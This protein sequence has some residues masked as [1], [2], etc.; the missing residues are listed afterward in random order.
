MNSTPRRFTCS[1]HWR[2]CTSAATARC[3]DG[4]EPAPIVLLTN[5]PPTVTPNSRAKRHA[6][7][8]YRR[9]PGRN[10]P[11]PSTQ[12]HG[13]T[14]HARRGREGKQKDR[15]KSRRHDMRGMEAGGVPRRWRRSCPR[16]RRAPSWPATWWTPGHIHAET[17]A[18]S[19]ATSSA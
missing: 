7:E 16:S 19:Q 10:A 1:L 5:L 3:C 13:T 2:I 15:R 8:A 17:W 6:V 12:S 14:T 4:I 9:T 18:T 11:S